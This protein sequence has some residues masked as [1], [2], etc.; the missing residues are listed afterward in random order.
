M[1]AS[2]VFGMVV[3]MAAP[4]SVC[5]ESPERLYGF[6]PYNGSVST[7][8]EILSY[9]LGSRHTVLM[10]QERVLE[11]ITGTSDRD[12]VFYYG[13]STEGRPLR[14]VAF[15][16]PKN[17]AR[18]DAIQANLKKIANGEAGDPNMPALVWINECIHG[19]ET[20]SFESAM[21]LMYNLAASENPEVVAAL[22]KVVVMVNPCYN[23]DGHER[24]VVA[25]NS[26]PNG[27]GKDGTFDRAIPWPFLGRLNH[28]R[29]DMNRDRIA[30]SQAETRA[31]V[32]FVLDWN[33]QVYADQHGQVENYFMPPVQQSINANVDRDRYNKWTDIFGR[34]TAGA[35]DRE[36]WSYYI[37]DSFDLYAPC[38]LDSFVSLTG[39]I[40]MTHETNGG[41][42]VNIE[43]RDGFVVT[44]REGL[45]KHVVSA[46][47]VIL[48]SADK[49]DELLSDY[50]AFKKKAVSGD[51]AGDFRT[52]VMRGTGEDLERMQLHLGRAGVKSVMARD[53]MLR[54]ARNYWTGDR[55]DVQVMENCLVVDMAQTH[56]PMAKALLEPMSEFEPDFIERQK[57][58]A[59]AMKK[60]ESFPEI[61]SFE[62]YD[63]TAWSLPYAYG[64]EAWW[65]PK[66]AEIPTAMMMTGTGVYA[67]ENTVG[68]ALRYDER[69]DLLRVFDLL[70]RGVRVSQLTK[71]TPVQGMV[72]EPGTFIVMKQ[73][74][75]DLDF[76]AMGFDEPRNQWEVLGTSYPDEGRYG[77]GGESV[78]HLRKPTLGVVFGNAGELSGGSFWFL[79]DKEFFLPY[80]SLMTRSVGGAL[81][82]LSCLVVPSGV[83]LPIDDRLKEWISD[84][85]S[86]VYLG[87]DTSGLIPTKSRSSF[88]WL[89]G[90]LFRGE[91]DSSHWLSYG[92]ARDAEGK[93][94]I[95]LPV[96]GSTFAE[97][98][99]NSVVTVS[100]NGVLSGWV[101]D[102]SAEIVGGTSWVQSRSL[103]NGSVTWF[104]D[105]P[106]DRAQWP[107]LWKM[108]LN[109]MILGAE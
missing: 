46:M 53:V 19:D 25:Y 102:D 16:S 36:G 26:I 67:V 13:Q 57:G 77:P 70:R 55:G 108:L 54:D 109:A 35:F 43:E 37:R 98:D 2:L 96:S 39:A 106:T 22:D 74:N 99:D 6:G 4:C 38:Y 20:A 66:S 42:L 12:R 23:P 92:Y 83:E 72:F 88:P 9:E 89:P 91:M 69:S 15:S 47:S 27:N 58:L 64:L 21:A 34:A 76:A 75:P 103:G 84:G 49:R 73:R 65:S 62:F 94:K 28:Y 10:D 107:G 48:S 63:L 86:L 14:A 7:P 80:R 97:A 90:A 52:V 17:I 81:K 87:G 31:E 11:A 71:R 79:M 78:R 18:L 68:Y 105:D 59:N 3:G 50:L 100:P 8:E 95:A 60:G 41:R 32:R 40:G 1:I 33:P 44:L 56:G 51:H 82:D 85:G 104:A 101:W 30:L 61:D 5:E 93:V 29:F 45:E 24:Y